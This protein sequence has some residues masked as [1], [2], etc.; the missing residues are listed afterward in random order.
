MTK[1]DLVER[2]AG[3]TG[4]SKSDIAVVVDAFLDAITPAAMEAALLAE[5]NIEADHDA[6]IAQWRLQVERL[7]YEADRAERRYRA[8][9]PE[10]RLVART[11]EIQWES[12]LRKLKD[13][14]KELERWQRQSP[15]RL[16]LDQ[17]TSIRNFGKDLKR[18]WQAPTTT[19]RERKELLQPPAE[20]GQRIHRMSRR[21]AMEG[22]RRR[23]DDRYPHPRS[24]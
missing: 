3:K 17:R 15:K 4:L 11:L 10:N 9:E 19:Y 5:K 18:V 24:R 12:C 22:I 20:E 13:A 14:E 7:R 1:A 16:T 21:S 6:A 23:T 2:V 8:V